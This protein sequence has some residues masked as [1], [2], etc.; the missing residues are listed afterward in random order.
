VPLRIETQE[1]P[2]AYPN[3]ELLTFDF[4]PK[5]MPSVSG[6]FQESDGSEQFLVGIHVPIKKGVDGHEEQI[7][8]S[9]TSDYPGYYLGCVFLGAKPDPLEHCATLKPNNDVELTLVCKD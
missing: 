1:S 9:L 7:F 8:T 4:Q 3:R 5:I 2:G 6:P